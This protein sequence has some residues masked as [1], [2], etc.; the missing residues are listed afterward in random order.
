VHASAKVFELSHP[1]E[2]GGGGLI[3]LTSGSIL[4]SAGS[5]WA[6]KDLLLVFIPS[7]AWMTAFVSISNRLHGSPCFSTELESLKNMQAECLFVVKKRLLPAE[8]LL[9]MH[10]VYLVC[11]CSI[12]IA[13]FR[14]SR[15]GVVGMQQSISVQP[16]TPPPPQFLGVEC[17]CDWQWES[18][19][20]GGERG[21]KLLS[22]RG[23]ECSP[24]HLLQLVSQHAQELCV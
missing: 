11:V 7:N 14:Y 1:A 18:C 15:L 5:L 19:Q 10:Q 23:K 17:D 9:M 20:R 4:L 6:Q 22:L 12:I 3:R 21:S 13:S 16:I 24:I 8:C 2:V